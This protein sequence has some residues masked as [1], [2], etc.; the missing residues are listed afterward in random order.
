MSGK[1]PVYRL[2]Q[3]AYDQLW[4]IAT[5][6]PD[7]YLD[8]KRDFGKAL[9]DRGFPN[10][11]EETGLFSDGPIELKPVESGPSNRADAQALRF[12]RSLEGMT[13][14]LALDERLWA[15]MTHFPLHAYGIKRWSRSKTT[16][17]LNYVRAHWFHSGICRRPLATQYRIAHLVDGTHGNKGGNGGCWRL[18]GRGRGKGVLRHCGLL[19][20]ADVLQLH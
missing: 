17:L 19:S 8:P 11:L 3:E 14:R 16:N 6:C 7:K 20:S 12:H 18:Q 1:T 5:E 15:W 2:T 10:Y 9:R 4:L 13:P